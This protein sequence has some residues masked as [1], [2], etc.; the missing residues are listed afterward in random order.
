M[1]N[2]HNHICTRLGTQIIYKLWQL[3]RQ[4]AGNKSSRL[5]IHRNFFG[6]KFYQNAML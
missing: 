6:C 3:F 1:R 2:T 5:L 4:Q